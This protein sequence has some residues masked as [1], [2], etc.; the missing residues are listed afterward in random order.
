ML[1]SLMLAATMFLVAVP[2]TETLTQAER[3]KGIAELEGSK[4]MFLDATKGLSEAQW[5]FKAA[6]DRWSIAECAEHIALSEGFIFGRITDG[7]MKTPLTPEKRSATAGKDDKLVP[8]LQ[9]RSYK[10]KA[11]EAIDPTKKPMGHEESVKL[12]LDSRAKSEDFI[13]TT[14]E[15][16]RDHIADHPVPAIGT[17]DA[18]QWVL[19]MSGHT[20]RHTLQILEVKADP[21]FPKM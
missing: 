7:V 1:K 19:F 20:R 18:F 15:D 10:A 11:P 5:N 9:D 17:M 8:M 4:K 14:Q 13:K 6:P 2:A 12:F 3:E 21:N 16:L